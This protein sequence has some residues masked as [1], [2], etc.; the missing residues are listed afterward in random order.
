MRTHIAILR[1]INVGGK[2]KVLMKDLKEVFEKLEFKNVQTYIQSGNIIFDAEKKLSNSSIERQIEDAMASK[3]DF[4][5]SVIVR[6]SDQLK[7]IITE[8]P[9]QPIENIKKH[10]LVFLKDKPAAEHVSLIE[11]TDSDDSFRIVDDHIYV[12]YASRYSDSK[13]S[14]NFF[15]NKLKVPASTRNWK[16]LHKLLEISNS[17]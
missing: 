1:G 16:T 4:Q 3:Y 17:K 11:K 5:V 10:Y 7:K 8:N 2:R 14:N 12:R 6:T 13:L 15:E 9:F